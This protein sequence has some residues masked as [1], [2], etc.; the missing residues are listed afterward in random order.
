MDLKPEA[1]V[2][3]AKASLPGHRQYHAGNGGD[4]TDGESLLFTGEVRTRRLAADESM[5]PHAVA[6]SRDALEAAGRHELDVDR[7]Y[8]Y[9]SLSRHSAPNDIF[10]VHR[11]L[12]LPSSCGVVPI[13]SEFTNLLLGII[14]SWEAIK[15]GSIRTALVTVGASW[16]GNLNYSRPHAA[17][18]SDAATAIVITTDGPGLRIVDTA[19]ETISSEYGAMT[20]E[21]RETGRISFSIE[22]GTGREAFHTTGKDGPVRLVQSLLSKHSISPSEIALVSHQPSRVL[23]DHWNEHIRPSR[24]LETF[25]RFGNMLHSS[26]GVTLAEY[27]K[28]I[29]E[30]YVVL[31]GLGL[32]SQ[33]VAVLLSVD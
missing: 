21:D 2:A 27:W 4:L 11:D 26:I 9:L 31:V 22:A 7:L 3:S 19:V 10:A 1:Y 24:H 28:D 33:N 30:P 18:I 14:N 16:S 8:G 13:N 17:Y 23:L 29:T 6:C 25:S 5:I 32:G 20:M 15:A 12:G